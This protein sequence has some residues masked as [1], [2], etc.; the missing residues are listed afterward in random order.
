MISFE[1][2]IKTVHKS[3]QNNV[4]NLKYKVFVLL[5]LELVL[6]SLLNIS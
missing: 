1:K 3:L 4:N 2:Y 6:Y 5:L